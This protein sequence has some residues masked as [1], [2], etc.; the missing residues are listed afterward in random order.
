MF[1]GDNSN[2]KNRLKNSQYLS[3]VIDETT[4]AT[5]QLRI[6]IRG[7]FSNFAI[8]EDFLCLIPM[9]STTAGK[10]FIK[11]FCNQWL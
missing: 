11:N 9:N 4:D 5:A 7:I 8:F 10:I 3:I 6:F 2:Q 1:E